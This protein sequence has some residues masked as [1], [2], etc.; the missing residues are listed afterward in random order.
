MGSGKVLD[1]NDLRQM[2]LARRTPLLATWEG[3]RR[4]RTR[5]VP[6]LSLTFSYDDDDFTASS[7]RRIIIKVYL[8]NHAP[9][10]HRE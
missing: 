9:L 1:K 10:A 7:H 5:P 3:G 8:N 6:T 4:R 2:G